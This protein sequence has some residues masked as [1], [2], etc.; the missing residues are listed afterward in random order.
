MYTRLPINNELFIDC[1]KHLAYYRGQTEIKIPWPYPDY[2][3]NFDSFFVIRR[4]MYVTKDRYTFNNDKSAI[5]FGIDD[6]L[7]FAEGVTFVF[8]HDNPS[9][10]YD[11]VT[12]N[13]E[14][15][16]FDNYTVKIPKK[17][18]ITSV[19]FP[20]T[21]T[22]D[23]LESMMIFVNSTFIDT[24]RYSISGNVVTFNVP[25]ERILPDSFDKDKS[26]TMAIARDNPNTVTEPIE[27]EIEQ[28]KVRATTDKQLLFDIPKQGDQYDNFV[29][30]LGSLLVSPSR[31][32]VTFDHKIL[33]LND[34]YD[35]VIKNKSLL[36]IFFKN[37][38][39]TGVYTGNGTQHIVTKTERKHITSTSKSIQIPASYNN[40]IHF[41][42]SNMLVFVN[43]TY[44][45]P[46]RYTVNNNIISLNDP[47]DYFIE[48]H[49][50]VSVF[51]Y[52]K[53]LYLEDYI[54]SA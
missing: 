41:N 36:F 49:E 24:E 52:K 35:A 11:V 13:E 6:S 26:F 45:E 47:D 34:T 10:E 30:M 15:I 20:H 27:I 16:Q 28:S 12:P 51:L 23:E 50:L 54:K 1:R 39:D 8:I 40:H 7:E 43:S 3:R 2:P 25:M 19:T 21:P 5:I 9:W 4:G 31:Y 53:K 48:G 14:F 37:K 33:F 32:F 18:T 22:S 29:I 44:Y 46:D 38:E 42:S 17:D